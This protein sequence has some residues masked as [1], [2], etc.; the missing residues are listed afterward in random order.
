M[1]SGTI[2]LSEWIDRGLPVDCFRKGYAEFVGNAIG[3]AEL[4]D[5]EITSVNFIN[6]SVDARFLIWCQMATGVSR[7]IGHSVSESLAINRAIGE[8]PVG[9]GIAVDQ[10]IRLVNVTIYVIIWLLDL[11]VDDGLDLRSGSHCNL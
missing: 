10:T 3:F 9:Q 1:L 2:N 5:Q 11:P 7:S 6:D 8:G 4:G